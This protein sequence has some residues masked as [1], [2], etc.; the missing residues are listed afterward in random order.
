MHIRSMLLL[1]AL[2]ARR[3]DAQS[4]R[5]GAAQSLAAFRSEAELQSFLRGLAADRARYRERHPAAHPTPPA[6]S[7]GV[8]VAGYAA[9][10]TSAAGAA[11]LRGRVTDAAGISL[12]GA[13]VAVAPLG[14][15]TQ[16]DSGGRYRLLLP[17]ERLVGSPTLTLTVRRIGYEPRALTRPFAEGDSVEVDVSLCQSA[18]QL[19]SVVM[20][21]AAPGAAPESVTNTQH[22]GVD[23][24]GIVK[25]HGR[26]LVI[27]RRG[28]LFTV[29]VGGGALRPV[30]AVDAFGPD[31]DP[32]DA[33]Y[34]ELLVHGDRVLVIG[35]SYAR[36][37]TEVG[38]F[39]M[40]TAG[41]LR[42]EATY[43]LRADDYYSSR[44]YASRI[45]G[46][47]LVL[48]SPLDLPLDTTALRAALPAMRRWDN[49]DT[50]RAFRPIVTARRIF[51][52]AARIDGA[53]ALALHTVTTCDLAAPTFHCAATAVAA[54]AGRVFYVSPS[55]VYVWANGSGATAVPGGAAPSPGLLYRMPLDGAAPAALRVQGTPVD[56]FSFLESADAHVNV[57]VRAASRG[58]A[59]W[60]AERSRG[61]TALL[62]VPIAHF[63]DGTRAAPTARYR[64]LP[65]PD[66]GPFQNRFVGDHLLYGT[67]NGWGRPGAGG[68]T[69]YAVQWRGGPVATIALPH[70]VD[71]IEALGR[72]AVVVGTD[73]RDLHLSGVGLEGGR[74]PAIRQ[75]FT[76]PEASQGE[77]RSHGFFYKPDGPR[78]GTLGLPV[79]R[80]ARPGY[81]QLF[82]GSAAVLFVRNAGGAFAPLGELEARDEG[83]ADDD[84]RA[85]CVDWYGNAR[86]LFLGKRV[87]ALLGYELVEG[88]LRAGRVEEVRR[89]DFAPR[90]AGIDGR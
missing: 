27:L 49:A 51:R 14:L 25:L 54:P 62:R 48:Y 80:A 26:H 61:G 1:L 7:G 36:G 39:R 22:D 38:A 82:E 67:G 17:A 63:G 40:D 21:A 32:D 5:G 45:V 83:A 43:Q 74:R 23:E 84:C 58:D 6:C 85:S 76:M 41:G 68:S 79:A 31:V 28:R 42:Y 34:D 70:H 10:G 56:Q 57:L 52:A 11:V 90:A 19:E 55:A 66:D 75:R 78:A 53:D 12:A 46:D 72:D 13:T 30:A 24:G 44:N 33:W 47:R 8:R 18:L 87:F 29:A 15:G 77:S 37:G 69:V 50:A 88:R 81:A 71:R 9:P 20:T 16:S 60:G 4:P 73:G 59:M 2:V 35:Y 65:A 3:A 86:P 89:V 64:A